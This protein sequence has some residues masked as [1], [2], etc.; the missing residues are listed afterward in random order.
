MNSKKI[1]F[2]SDFH[3]GVPTHE[4]SL[5]REKLVC[6]WLDTIK[7]D[8]SEI[9]LVGDI[10]D[11]WYEYKYTIPKGQTRLLGKIAEITDSGIAVHFFTGNHDLWM[12]DYF[13]QELNV[14]IHYQPITVTY[15][16]K[17]FYIAHGDGLGPGDQW[18]KI[19]KKIFTNKIIQW[20]FTR[21]HPNLAFYIARR[22]SKRSR[23]STSNSDEKFL[24]LENEWLYLYSCE[25]LKTHNVNY[26]VFGH[27]HLPL[28]LNV[29]K[30]ATYINLGE[31][32]NYHTYAV[33]DGEKIELKTF[34]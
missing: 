5:V 4:L 25:Y 11:F 15:N 34:V 18:Y 13:K 7:H 30:N 1:Y 8:A 14:Q 6:K 16:N 28:E 22:S 26:F 2:A 20:M 21:I 32:I 19:L 10:F 31:W 29:G 17:V 24:G 12:K 23:I 33:F 9:Y 27:R 3:L